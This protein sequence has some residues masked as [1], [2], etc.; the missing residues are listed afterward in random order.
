MIVTAFGLICRRDYGATRGIRSSGK[1]IKMVDHAQG[2]Q[3]LQRGSDGLA[4][5]EQSR[6]A[7]KG[8]E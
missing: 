7:V 2:R 5:P 8:H 3:G 6:Q 1:L 4:V